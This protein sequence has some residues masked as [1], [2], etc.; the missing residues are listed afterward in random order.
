[1]NKR[2]WTKLELTIP[3]HIA[4]YQ[5]DVV[6][7]ERVD[8]INRISKEVFNEDLKTLVLKFRGA[9]MDKTKTKDLSKEMIEVLGEM[10]NKTITQARV[11]VEEQVDILIDNYLLNIAI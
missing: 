2:N 9:M 6:G 1:M 10:K 3:H 8:L 7:Y 4:K 5:E 11:V